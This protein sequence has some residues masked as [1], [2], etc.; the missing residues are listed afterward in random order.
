MESD[1]SYELTLVATLDYEDIMSYIT[2]ELCN[3]IAAADLAD[4]MEEKLDELCTTPYMGALVGN[5][6]LLRQDIR[7]I[8][9]KH[10][11]IYYILN[12]NRQKIVVIRIGH[13]LQ[14]QEKLLERY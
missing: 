7:F 2:D 5:P 11:I 1:Y 8:T 13:F 4:D 12:A 14:D 3:P 9:V 10:Y 6:A